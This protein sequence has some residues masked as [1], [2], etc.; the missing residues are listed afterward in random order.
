MEVIALH[1]APINPL[2]LGVRIYGDRLAVPLESKPDNTEDSG[3]EFIEMELNDF[4]VLPLASDN[5][6][7]GKKK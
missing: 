6:K 5:D 7:R 2:F 4:L 1:K 3:W